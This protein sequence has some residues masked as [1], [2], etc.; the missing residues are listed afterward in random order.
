MKNLGIVLSIVGA[1]CAAVGYIKLSS[2]EYQL[3]YALGASD[4]TPN[5]LLWIGIVALGVGIIMVI[6]GVRQGK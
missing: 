4:G 2:L 5:T 6:S 3:S 1:I